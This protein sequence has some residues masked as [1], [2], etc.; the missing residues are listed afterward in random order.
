MLARA[1]RESGRTLIGE[2]ANVPGKGRLYLY[3]YFSIETLGHPDIRF[4]HRY[5]DAVGAAEDRLRQVP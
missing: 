5:A 1:L 2:D 3:L 4:G